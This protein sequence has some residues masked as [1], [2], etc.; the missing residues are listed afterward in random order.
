MWCIRACASFPLSPTPHVHVHD[1]YTQLAQMACMWR[2]S[3]SDNAGERPSL[4]T[5]QKSWPS[6]QIIKR[7]VLSPLRKIPGPKLAAL[8]SLWM[9]KRSNRFSF[10]VTECFVDRTISGDISECTYTGR[11]FWGTQK[12]DFLKK[13][14]EIKEGLEIR[15]DCT[16]W[17]PDGSS[18][19]SRRVHDGLQARW[20]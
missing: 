13:N 15:A 8:T 2:C 11:L 4:T 10:L 7:L 20:L 5:R 17:T 18:T 9:L 6:R 12:I 16:Y 3:C 19:K 1:G 14:S